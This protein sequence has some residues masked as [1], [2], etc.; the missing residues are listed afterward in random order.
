[1]E[2]NIRNWSAI[3]GID[4]ALILSLDQGDTLTTYSQRCEKY[5]KK[6][7]QVGFKVENRQ[8]YDKLPY[9]YIIAVK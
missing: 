7:K 3:E 9:R 4:L 8:L 1:M 5:E 2:Y 6:F